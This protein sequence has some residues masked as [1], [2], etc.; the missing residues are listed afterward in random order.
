MREGGTGSP[1]PAVVRRPIIDHL[2]R[3]RFD[4][5]LAIRLRT[6]YL[7]NRSAR[8]EY[9]VDNVDNG[10]RPAVAETV[11]VCVEVSTLRSI[12]WRVIWRERV[13]EFKPENLQVARMTNA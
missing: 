6:S 5:P 7:G 3:A 1:A 9:L 2:A 4:D 11:I 8:I 13:Q 12:P 10:L